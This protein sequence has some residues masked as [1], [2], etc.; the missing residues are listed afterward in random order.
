M[1]SSHRTAIHV[2]EIKAPR[3]GRNTPALPGGMRG[4]IKSAVI[5]FE[6]CLGVWNH[7]S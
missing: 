7:Q 5:P 6:G 1:C 3:L 2:C 4:A